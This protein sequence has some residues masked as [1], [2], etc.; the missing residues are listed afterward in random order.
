M[1]LSE[2]DKRIVV[3]SSRYECPISKMILISNL[4]GKVESILI[5]G[6]R[7]FETSYQSLKEGLRGGDLR[8]CIHQMEVQK[9]SGELPPTEMIILDYLTQ[10]YKS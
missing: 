7:S 2:G 10:L 5:F 1:K 3:I 9:N 6:D 4:E 8:E